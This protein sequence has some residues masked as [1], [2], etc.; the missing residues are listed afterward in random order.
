MVM[1]LRDRRQNVPSERVEHRL[2]SEGVPPAEVIFHVGGEID[3]YTEPALT[4]CLNAQLQPGR[5]LAALVVDLSAVTFV[6]A[7]GFAALLTVA[8]NASRRDVA[9]CLAGC[10]PQILRVLAVLDTDNM[11]TVRPDADHLRRTRRHRPSGTARTRHRSEVRRLRGRAGEVVLCSSDLYRT[12]DHV[13]GAWARA[14]R[15]ISI[16]TYRSGK[17]E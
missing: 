9:F 5:H 10:S 14:P 12:D 1:D 2:R 11:L 16:T 8:T 7:R 13:T 17:T 6:G 3:I 15:P 4:R